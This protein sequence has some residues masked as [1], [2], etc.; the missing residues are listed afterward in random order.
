[1]EM[2]VVSWW[3]PC[4]FLH[5]SHHLVL[6]PITKW[7]NV[8][9]DVYNSLFLVYFKYSL[10]E[11]LNLRWDCSRLWGSALSSYWLVPDLFSMLPKSMR[12]GVKIPRS[13]S[14]FISQKLRWWKHLSNP[15]FVKIRW[16]QPLLC[17][18]LSSCTSWGRHCNLGLHPSLRVSLGLVSSKSFHGGDYSLA[19]WGPSRDENPRAEEASFSTGSSEISLSRLSRSFC[20][21]PWRGPAPLCLTKG[22]CNRRERGAMHSLLTGAWPSCSPQRSDQ[23]CSLLMGLKGGGDVGFHTE[24]WNFLS[25]GLFLLAACCVLCAQ[26][27]SVQQEPGR[28]KSGMPTVLETCKLPCS[29]RPGRGGLSFLRGCLNF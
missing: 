19:A 5:F 7:E 23:V 12:F 29:A 3:K 21:Q 17:K 20:R 16:G 1:M 24:S 22:I 4:M 18:W 11:T 6:F 9:A 26:G 14:C 25:A 13:Q 8:M 15:V 10:W 2:C 28:L 27:L